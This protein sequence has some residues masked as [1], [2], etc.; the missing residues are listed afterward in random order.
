MLHM[1]VGFFLKKNADPAP[2]QTKK[3]ISKPW[4]ISQSW[5]VF[6]WQEHP[7]Q[8]AE[9]LLRLGEGVSPADS[10]GLCLALLHPMPKTLR[11]FEAMAMS[12]GKMGLFYKHILKNWLAIRCCSLPAIFSFQESSSSCGLVGWP[13]QMCLFTVIPRHA[14][15]AGSNS[16]GLEQPR[17]P[18]RRRTWGFFQYARLW[19]SYLQFIP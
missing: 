9:M 1:R 19:L 11:G 18:K 6:L 8:G 4:K 2:G 3:Q 7:P 12:R 14:P 10:V 13:G 5:I 17:P 15:E 16:M